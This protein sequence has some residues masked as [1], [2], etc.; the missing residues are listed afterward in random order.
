MIYKI[1]AINMP[2][3]F[4]RGGILIVM[5]R[6]GVHGLIQNLTNTD[7]IAIAESYEDSEVE[8]LRSLPEWQEG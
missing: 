6:D 4:N 8:V 7:G 2:K 5:N 3:V 1:S